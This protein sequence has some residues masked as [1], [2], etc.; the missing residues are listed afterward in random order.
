MGDRGREID[1]LHAGRRHIAAQVHICAGGWH[2]SDHHVGQADALYLVGV[3]RAFVVEDVAGR[4]LHAR[5]L[6]QA[7]DAD[8]LHQAGVPHPAVPGLSYLSELKE[9]ALRGLHPVVEVADALH[10]A[11]AIVM[12]LK[13]ANMTLLSALP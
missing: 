6:V 1:G 3:L 8:A 7:D 9:A 10:R 5:H 12:V 2:A 4:A 13:A 11:I